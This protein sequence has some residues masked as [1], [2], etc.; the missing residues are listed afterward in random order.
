[1]KSKSAIQD[2]STFILKQIGISIHFV[3]SSS[4]K[5]RIENSFARSSSGDTQIAL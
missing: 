5:K 4:S 3:S 2:D 1:L